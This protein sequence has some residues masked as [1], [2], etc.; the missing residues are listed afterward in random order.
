M[1]DVVVPNFRKRMEEGEIINNP[2]TSVDETRVLGDGGFLLTK[3]VGS[4][5]YWGEIQ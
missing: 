1:T 4:V 2:M 3:K 5:T